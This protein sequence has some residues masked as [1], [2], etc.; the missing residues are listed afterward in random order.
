MKPG[1]FLTRILPDEVMAELK[2]RFDLKFNRNDRPLVKVELIRGM[3]GK[4]ALISMLS[5][6]I[7]DEVIKSNPRLKVI[8]NYAVG[9]NNIDLKAASYRGIVVSNTPGVLTEATADLTW[10]LILT[11]SR[12]VLEGDRLVRSGRWSGWNPTQLLGTDLYGKTLGIIGMG[13]IGQ[14]VAGRAGGFGMRVIYHNR[15]RLPVRFEKQFNASYRP[16]SGVLRTADILSLHLPLTPETRHMIDRQVLDRMKSSAL[17]INTARGPI[18][19]ERALADALKHKNIAG[20]GLDVF[21]E[22]PSVRKGLISLSNVVLLP[23]LGSAT[24]ETRT[25][26]GFIVIRNIQSVL[27][28]K[29]APNAVND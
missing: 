29:A 16:L 20:A 12:R 23:H 8:A 7:D 17:L 15:R 26:M 25:K 27:K 1:V 28:G 21:E 22:E 6:S 4:P 10:S 5:D 2:R 13:R 3:R 18:V 24:I 11:L 19:D 9:I 14:A